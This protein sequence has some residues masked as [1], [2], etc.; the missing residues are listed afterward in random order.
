M[1]DL[2]LQAHEYVVEIPGGDLNLSRDGNP[3]LYAI[4]RASNPVGH[5]A[6]FRGESSFC[7]GAMR[8]G[9]RSI[10]APIQTSYAG[11]RDMSQVLVADLAADVV[12]VQLRHREPA[13]GRQT[14][15]ANYLFPGCYL[16]PGHSPKVLPISPD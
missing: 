7:G 14:G 2:G 5:T 15:R 9:L 8:A 12:Q 6:L 3:P 10:A 11:L 13:T 4:F 16:L 1:G